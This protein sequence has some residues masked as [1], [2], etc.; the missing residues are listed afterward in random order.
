MNNKKLVRDILL[1]MLYGTIY[2]FFINRVSELLTSDTVYEEKIKKMISISFIV[3]IVG[4][5]LAFKIFS[6]GRLK[7]RIIKY[8]LVVG[9]SVILLNSIVYHWPELN[10]DT[11]AFMIGTLLLLL[12]LTS[13]RL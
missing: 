11:K 6:T 12:F 2:V 13:Y 3:V 1:S 10:N 7:N 4:M 9:S 5:V 8:T